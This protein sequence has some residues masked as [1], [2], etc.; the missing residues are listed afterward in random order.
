MA[1]NTITNA[2]F[3][4]PPRLTGSPLTDMASIAEWLWDF[5]ATAI[6]GRGLLQTQA[7][8][9][10]FAQQFPELAAQGFGALAVLNEVDLNT[11]NDAAVHSDVWTPTLFNGTNLAA[12]V[13]HDGRFI[14]VGNIVQCAG[15]VDVDPTAA[16]KTVLG[17]SLPLTSDFTADDQ[18]SGCAASIEVAGFSAGVYADTTNNRA[19]IEWIAV[20]TASR[21]LDFTFTYRIITP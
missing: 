8:S 12:S 2:G 13:A 21:K 19:T 6:V 3:S 16:G 11:I 14:R 9:Q 4:E 7:L 15:R 18:L 10:E 17:V 5:Y 1:E 20:D